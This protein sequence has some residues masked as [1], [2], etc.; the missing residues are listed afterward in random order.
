MV[1]TR[2][3]T[4]I[5]SEFRAR[6]FAGK[7]KV[8]NVSEGGLFVNTLAIPEVGESIALKLTEPGKPPIQVKG[9]VWW[10]TNENRSP[11]SGFGLRLLEPSTQYLRLVERLK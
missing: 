2:V 4:L 8:R 5:K 10:A 1:D 7:G 9:F 3:R 6:S 11:Q